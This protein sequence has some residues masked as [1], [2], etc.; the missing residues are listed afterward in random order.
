M[1]SYLNVRIYI[2]IIT[3]SDGQELTANISTQQSSFPFT[4]GT[5]PQCFYS[6]GPQGSTRNSNGILPHTG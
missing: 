4:E 5:Q 2:A 1:P 3:Q 6:I